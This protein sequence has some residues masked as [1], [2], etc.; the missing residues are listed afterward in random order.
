LKETPQPGGNG[1]SESQIF[2]NTS[3]ALYG[4]AV[5]SSGTLYVTDAMNGDVFTLTPP[6]YNPTTILTGLTGP[7]GI[8]VDSAGFMY[9]ADGCP[10]P[11]SCAPAVLK[12]PTS[13]G[14]FVVIADSTMVKNPFDVALDAS[15]DV[16]IA[17]FGAGAVV[18]LTP[19]TGGTYN[20]TQVP[21]AYNPWGVAVN[22]NGSIFVAESSGSRVVQ[23]TPSGESVVALGYQ[24]QALAFDSSGYLYITDLSFLGGPSSGV[25][26]AT[27]SGALN[28]GAEQTQNDGNSNVGVVTFFFYDA[29]AL[30]S[31]SIIPGEEFQADGTLPDTCNFTSYSAGSYC[32]VLVGFLP[33]YSGTRNG[34]VDFVDTSGNVLP[35]AYV[36]GTGLGPQMAFLPATGSMPA[37]GY[38]SLLAIASNSLE[39]FPSSLGGF[40]TAE[41]TSV[42]CGGTDL[43]GYTFNQA[44]AVAVDGAQNIYV[45]EVGTMT[46][47]KMTCSGS[48]CSFLQSPVAAKF[49]WNPAAIAADI[50]GNVYIG[51]TENNVV[52]KETLQPGGTYS[53]STV[54]TTALASPAGVAVDGSGNVY[55]ADE[56][57]NQVLKETPSAL[58][59]TQSVVANSSSS[60]YPLSQ[61]NAVAVDGNGIVYIVDSGNDR[62]I[63]E[64]PSGGTYTQSLVADSSWGLVSPV[65]V[66]ADSTGNV[67]IADSSALE[68]LEADLADAPPVGFGSVND[69]S[70]S[71]TSVLVF[72]V[73]NQTLSAESNPPSPVG[74]LVFGGSSDFTQ[75]AGSGTPPDCAAGMSFSLTQQT[76]CNLAI[77]FAPVAGESGTITGSVTLTDNNLNGYPS[78]AQ[79]ITLSGTAN[80]A[81]TS[82]TITFPNPGTQT[83]GEAPITLTAYASS[84]LTVTYQVISG[85]ASVSG[86]TLTINGAGQVKV[87]A[88]QTGNAQY[89]AATPVQDT[90]TV[91][92]ATPAFS[93]LSSPIITYGA[94]ST[95]LSGTISAVGPLYPTGDNVSITLN[96]VV[97]QAAVQA[98]GSFS[99]SFAT[100]TLGASNTPYSISYSYG[101]DSNFAS[102]SGSSSLTVNQ[103]SQS[104]VTVA[105]PTSV[106]Y[107]TTGTATANGGNGTGGYVF[108]TATGTTGCSV[109]GTTVSVSNASGVCYLQAYRQG[110]SNYLQS[111][112]SASFTVTLQK[113]GPGFSNLSSPTITYGTATTILSGTISEVPNGESVSITLNGVTQTATVSSGAFSSSFS[114]PALAVSG[115]PYTITY[116]YAGDSNFNSV[117]DTSKRLTV[118]K[119]TATVTLSNLTQTYTGAALYP[120]ATTTP[121]GLSVAW[122]GA[123]DTTVG[124]YAVSAT[125]NNP[126]YTSNTA[127]GTFVIQQAT[128]VIN[129][130]TP[131]PITYGTALSSTQL[132]ATATSSGVTVNG[133]YAYKPPAGAVLNAGTQTLNVTFTP[134]DGTDY[135]KANGSVTL[136][137]NKATPAITWANPAAITYGTPLGPQQ[138]DATASIPGTFVYTPKART[139]LGAGVQTLSV[140]FTPAPSGPPNGGNYTT[141]TKTVTITVTAAVLT[142]TANK[143]SVPHNRPIPPLRYTVT[144][145]VNGDN[146]S[147]LSGSPNESTTA[148][149]G[150]PVGKYPITI[151]QGT[152][153][154]ANYTFT[155]VNG[156]L[157]ITP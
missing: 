55:I 69:G 70:S 12:A 47:W 51:D 22:G 112:T 4:V 85:P 103:A 52:L 128:P 36:Y 104:T 87:E 124:K 151:T 60:P 98:D 61:P 32:N 30:A 113:A 131:T 143:V 123:P 88:D 144:G 14:S 121:T 149:Q 27:L 127:S 93:G 11:F 153:S 64:T 139:V 137:V 68:V 59:Y 156:T 71:T 81:K 157:N 109:S 97:Q 67:Y 146:K 122:T 105:G 44:Q 49:D 148:K 74:G 120:T 136:T 116:Y 2:Y 31:A 66:A 72:N 58:G 84:G 150:S 18:E 134:S 79:T 76:A 115:S 101:G 125:V 80:L 15:G 17:D 41:G 65:G 8:A 56:K 99:S 39:G 100:G 19:A 102:A 82:Q 7:M 110:D 92:Q 57:N 9:I 23:L 35:N 5:D 86:S 142:V 20:V 28:L 33:M 77:Q 3:T 29:V 53:E 130:S 90:F 126:N 73:G 129:W 96:G 1:Y 108:S 34:S 40:C 154:A 43:T 38:S 91:N 94:A 145:F 25:M 54:A 42:G 141:A 118:N 106:T 13:G 132:D 119:A 21:C 16:Y 152:L 10:G 114:T 24:P 75:V 26:K 140:V 83:Y 48:P 62:V 107:G 111:A 95:T 50:S 78:A 155:F 37:N 133:T 89:A 117:S 45:S 135:K 6:T 63:M 138:L 46:V 147:V